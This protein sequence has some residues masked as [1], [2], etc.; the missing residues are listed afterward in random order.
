MPLQCIEALKMMV[1]GDTKGWAIMGWREKAMGIIKTARG[2]GLPEPRQKA[3]EF[4]NLLG[5]RRYF[6]FLDLLREPVEWNILVVIR[7][8]SQL[9]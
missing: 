2:S 3:E 7:T 1:E 4:V 5:S 8:L 6:D 9:Q